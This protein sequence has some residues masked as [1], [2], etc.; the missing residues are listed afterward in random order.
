MKDDL[1]D[2]DRSLVD[3]A[4][5][6]SDSLLYYRAALDYINLRKLTGI[7]M[8]SVEEAYLEI[9][10][11]FPDKRTLAEYFKVLHQE[12]SQPA[13]RLRAGTLLPFRSKEDLSKT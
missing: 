1:V 5:I 11:K 3:K 10:R 6:P 12:A 8:P 7:P 13:P 4:T 9:K 2:G